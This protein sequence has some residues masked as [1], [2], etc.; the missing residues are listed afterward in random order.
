MPM[1]NPFINLLFK[2]TTVEAACKMGKWAWKSDEK[3]WCLGVMQD[4]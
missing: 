1:S 3:L 4:R 2:I